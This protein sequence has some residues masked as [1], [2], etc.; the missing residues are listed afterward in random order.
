MTFACDHTPPFSIAPTSM[1]TLRSLIMLALPLGGCRFGD[2]AC[3]V[4]NGAPLIT[5]AVVRDSV[6]GT[7]IPEIRVSDV[8]YQGG[9][10]TD[11]RPTSSC[12]QS[13]G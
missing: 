7:T 9:A 10:V 8:F 12:W 11:L 3:L 13:V 2:E 1:R 4:T 6:A 5:I